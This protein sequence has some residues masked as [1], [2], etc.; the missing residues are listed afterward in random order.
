MNDVK[1]MKV[2]DLIPHPK[3]EEIYGHDEDISDLVETIRK[4]GQVHTLTVTP[5]G[6]ILAG[7][8][9]RKA[10][11][12]LGI[13]EVNVEV[14]DLGSPEEEI[15][16]LV[17]NNKQRD[18]TNE[19]KA[20]EAKALKEVESKLALERKSENGGDRKSEKYKSEVPDSAHAILKKQG[21]ARDAVAKNVGFRSGHE[22]DR[23]I[24]TINKIEELKEEG[25]TED[26]ELIRGALNN[27]RIS[28][29]EEL[30]RN[31]DI[32]EIPDEDKPLIKSGKK[33]AYSYVEK[34]KAKNKTKEEKTCITCGKTLPVD[35]FYDGR[36]ECKSCKNERDNE[37]KSGVFRDTMGNIMTYDK[38]IANSKEMEEAI[39]FLK[40]DD[41]ECDDT[42]NYDM[43]LEFFKLTLSNYY[44][45][46]QRFI[47]GE[48]FKDMPLGIKEKFKEEVDKLSNYVQ[49]LQMYLEK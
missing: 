18:K 4:S 28:S 1:R 23:A 3:N 41:S 9:R 6:V 26:A 12:E 15:R 36:N 39:A 40:R 2:I 35:M 14:V 29:A 46:N 19:Q 34:A 48:I 20:K 32:V 21:K 22:V 8:R 10:C 5:K 17:L 13:K 37:R 16:Y 45:E 25:R 42:I 44:F 38:S 47:D 31:I 24:K 30:A 27:G 43:E 7:H 11:M 33:S 49:L